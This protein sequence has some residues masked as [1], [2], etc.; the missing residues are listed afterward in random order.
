MEAGEVEDP[1]Q[2]VGPSVHQFRVDKL[3]TALTHGNA[4]FQGAIPLFRRGQ[5][6]HILDVF[7]EEVGGNGNGLQVVVDVAHEKLDTEH[8][9]GGGV[10]KGLGHLLLVFEKETVVFA[11][12]DVMQPVADAGQV[13]DGFGEALAVVAGEQGRVFQVIEAVEAEN[14]LGGPEHGLGIAKAAAA[15]LNVRFQQIAVVAEALVAQSTVAE[16]GL[17][18]F[19]A[20]VV[21]KEAAEGLHE[22]VKENL[23]TCHQT[24]IKE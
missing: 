20:M 15:L 6:H 23:G 18:E 17:K 19:L 1:H 5:A 21:D 3:D 8:G 11:A 9:L 22:L 24:G 10:V 4:A 2:E 7:K 13:V 16:H 12:T 14:H